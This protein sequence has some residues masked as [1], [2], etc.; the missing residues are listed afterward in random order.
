MFN[1]IY[2]WLGTAKQRLLK[3]DESMMTVALP[4]QHELP[5][6]DVPTAQKHLS[7][8]LNS[9]DFIPLNPQQ[10]Y[11]ALEPITY[12]LD[13][14]TQNLHQQILATSLPLS[15]K[16]HTRYQQIS[17]L[18]QQ[19]YQS[20]FQ[21]AQIAWAQTQPV[22][23]M[24]A[25]QQGM[26]HLDAQ[27]LT[28]Y[29]IYTPA[30]PSLW[31]AVHTLFALA[32]SHHVDQTKLNSQENPAY[33]SINARYKKIL[34]L[35][36]AQ[37][38]QLEH[39]EIRLL[40]QALTKLSHH[41]SLKTAPSSTATT[42]AVDLLQDQPPTRFQEH[43]TPSASLR[44]LDTQSLLPLL[45]NQLSQPQNL[46]P[47]F[48][49]SPH[50]PLRLIRKLILRCYPL[51][52]RKCS[53]APQDGQTA[54]ILGVDPVYA[55]LQQKSVTPRPAATLKTPV[56]DLL[57]QEK[58]A[59][60]T[61]S[62]GLK[63][64]QEDDIWARVYTGSQ[65]PQRE[66]QK[67]AATP[68][69]HWHIRDQGIHGLRLFWPH[70]NPCAARVGEL[71]ALRH[72]HHLPSQFN[73]IG[74]IRWVRYFEHPYCAERGVEIGV[75]TIATQAIAVECA[76][77][78]TPPTATKTRHALMLTDSQHQTVSLVTATP[79]F[80][81]KNQVEVGPVD[82]INVI[83]LTQI[84]HETGLLTQFIYRHCGLKNI[85][86]NTLQCNKNHHPDHSY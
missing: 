72:P 68:H 26:S 74:I 80:Q 28:T 55:A 16:T 6:M 1:H 61:L 21:Q 73:L 29:L 44:F 81:T 7:A 18:H 24:M 5:L 84:H 41:C 30:A 34:L 52:P 39:S 14:L 45:E 32:E 35:S 59:L 62:L 86:I 71:V 66:P 78:K 40:N 25:M 49:D 43:H 3:K 70:I 77:I 64:H 15:A 10:Q 47:D 85:P 17:A 58:P 56:W 79:S 31:R 4:W 22:D 9:A 82:T 76:L 69:L 33:Q 20:Y 48:T 27:F 8:W 36:L 75:E 13:T 19:L 23:A 53:R 65:L 42:H 46:N 51:Q 12:W 50:L 37:P 38:Y 57:P 67:T 83:E 2:Q 63:Q 54:L 11:Q 60:N